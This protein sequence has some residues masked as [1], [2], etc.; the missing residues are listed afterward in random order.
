LLATEEQMLNAAQ[1]AKV[2]G[3]SRATLSRYV[4]DGTLPAYRYARDL[5]FRQSDLERFIEKHKVDV[6]K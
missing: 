1:T 4:Q 6:K 3:I 5:R 2:L